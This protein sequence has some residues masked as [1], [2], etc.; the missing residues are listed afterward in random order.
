MATRAFLIWFLLLLVAI[1]NG[2]FREGI[3]LPRLDPIAAQAVSTLM[4]A[5]F[6]VLLGW[7]ALPWVGPAS[8]RQACAIGAGW[9]SLTL[10]FEFVAGHYL[11]GK[12]WQV[13]LADYDLRAG[14][15]WVLILVVTAFTPIVTFIQRDMGRVPH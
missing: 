11:F 5:A 15:I 10:G 8:M 6:I 9:G 3:L 13:L 2:A 1:V 4:L 12:P 7:V 14:R